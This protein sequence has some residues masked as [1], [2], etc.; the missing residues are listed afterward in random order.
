M[1]YLMI[2]SVAGFGSTGKI[3]AD[4]CRELERAGHNCILAYGRW[5]ENCDD[6]KTYRI[7]TKADCWIHG[8]ATRIYDAHGWGSIRATRKFLKWVDRYEPDVIWLHNIHGYYINIELLFGYLKKAG[9][10]VVWTL[11]DCWSFTG[12]C[13]YFTYINCDKWKTKCHHCKQKNRYPQ[14]FLLDN[15]MENYER[16]RKA[17][18]GIKDMTL[19]TPSQWLADLVKQ[20]FLKEY[21]VEVHYNVIDKSVFKPSSSDFRIEY[22]LTG[23]KVILGVANIWDERKGL[24][25]FIKLAKMLDE[26]YVI[27]LVGLTR[28]QIEHMPERIAGIKKRE[29]LSNLATVYTTADAHVDFGKE[30]RVGRTT[31]ESRECKT[32]AIVMKGSV[33][34]EAVSTTGG[35][36]VEANVE[37]VYK[38]ITG[39]EFC[40][41]GRDNLTIAALICMQRLD[42]SRKLAE[43]YSMADLFVNMTHEDNYPTVN[44]EAQACGTYVI[45]YDRGGCRETIL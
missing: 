2:N 35:E 42:N 15:S 9:K 6:I 14:S 45:A 17:F 43:I 24:D 13:A 18:C 21:P 37:S 19:I 38:A 23:K 44:L 5:K 27:V 32:S 25:D 20:S 26:N 8:L 34:G 33:C 1:K 4:Q 22:G 30:E 41:A 31:A 16:K 3:A 10:K 40:D 39:K 12:H 36:V 29:S 11:H 28:K 7:G